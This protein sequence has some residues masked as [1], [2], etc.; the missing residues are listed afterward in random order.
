ML[1]PSTIELCSLFVGE[2]ELSVALDVGKA[3][4]KSHRKFSPITWGQS[5]ELGKRTGF[6]S[7]ILPREVSCRKRFGV[8]RTGI[9]I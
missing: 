7:V 1:G 6:H 9:T 3:L 8:R 5:Q 2:P 4:P